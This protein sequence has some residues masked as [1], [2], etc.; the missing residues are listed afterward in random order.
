MSFTHLLPPLPRR[1]S[2]LR[3]FPPPNVDSPTA[4]PVPGPSQKLPQ[5]P[6]T[7]ALVQAR[8]F[9]SPVSIVPLPRYEQTTSGQAPRPRAGRPLRPADA[10]SRQIE[11][12]CV[13]VAIA[14]LE[15]MAARRSR[16]QLAQ[17]VSADCF[18]RLLP[19]FPKNPRQVTAEQ[20]LSK[21]PMLLRVR[22]QRVNP[23]LYEAVALFRCGQSIKVI[24]LQVRELH[25]AWFVTSIEQLQ[26]QT[27]VN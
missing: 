13:G 12:R 8:G 1:T 27:D 16:Q 17:W 24:A 22:A 19:R 14:Y 21:P 20:T 10:I 2:A 9:N 25:G 4:I 23:K 3:T 18:H 15:I 7:L 11:G 6:G 26:S 5:A